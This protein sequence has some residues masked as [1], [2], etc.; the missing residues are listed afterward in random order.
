MP[1][2]SEPKFSLTMIVVDHTWLYCFG[3]VGNYEI[4]DNTFQV[5]E[6]LNTAT[7]R[8]EDAFSEHN[9]YVCKWERID[10][11]SKYQSCC[12]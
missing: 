6:R 11:P 8:E 4:V 2:L 12:Q 3:G 1:E 7:L 9:K 10:L 5:I